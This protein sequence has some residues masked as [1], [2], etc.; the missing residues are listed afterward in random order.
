MSGCRSRERWTR[1][2]VMPRPVAAEESRKEL[3]ARDLFLADVNQRLVETE[4]RATKAE[5]KRDSLATM[6]AN[7]VDDRTWMRNFGVLNIVNTILDAP[8]NMDAVAEVVRRAL[9]V[10]Y[11]AGYTK[12]LTHVNAIS[13]KK[14]TDKRCALRDADTEAAMKTAVEAYNGLIVPAYAQIQEC[15]EV[16]DHVDRLRTLF[17]PKA[18]GEGGSDDVE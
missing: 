14:F 6:N 3:E 1:P 16:D 7:L 10:G 5:E 18:S 13:L 2:E 11:K 15:L 8:E 12:C 17:E 4:A 9:E